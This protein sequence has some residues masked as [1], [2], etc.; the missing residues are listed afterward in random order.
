M[1]ER[2]ETFGSELSG[3]SGD[4][5]NATP[6]RRSGPPRAPGL[7]SVPPALSPKRSARYLESGLSATA[8]AARMRDPG[9]SRG[10]DAA[11]AASRF[12]PP[13]ASAPFARDATRELSG[14]LGVRAR[15]AFEGGVRRARRAISVVA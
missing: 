12:R 6:P 14:V 11:S 5:T 4:S 1:V 10:G 7:A 2:A 15:R 13:L 8:A 9:V 3:P